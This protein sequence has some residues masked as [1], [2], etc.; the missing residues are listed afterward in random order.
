MCR[1]CEPWEEVTHTHFASISTYHYAVVACKFVKAGRP[2]LAILTL[3]AVDHK[4]VVINI[5]ADEDIGEEF[6]EC[7]F[8][9]TSLSNQEDGIICLNLVLRCLDD[10][11]LERLYVTRKYG[12]ER[13][14]KDVVK[15]LLDNLDIIVFQWV[16]SRI[17]VGG[18]YITRSVI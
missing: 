5:A 12:P 6:H 14:I 10:P 16:R 17:T 1:G 2:G 15:N 11:L 13:C 7:G 9:D 18:N 8:A 3:V 4:A